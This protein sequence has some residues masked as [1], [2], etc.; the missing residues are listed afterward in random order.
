MLEIILMPASMNRLTGEG[1]D[2]RSAVQN[3]MK[4]ETVFRAST[5]EN[6]IEDPCPE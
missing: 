6:R 1:V 5:E 4:I 2:V 3:V